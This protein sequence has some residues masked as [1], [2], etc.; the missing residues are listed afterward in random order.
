MLP[1]RS[2]APLL[3]H[4]AFIQFCAAGETTNGGSA[5]GRTFVD[6]YGAANTTTHAPSSQHALLAAAGW[7]QLQASDQRDHDQPQKSAKYHAG[8]GRK[9]QA[10]DAV[11][12]GVTITRS[13]APDQ[14]VT[15]IYDGTGASSSDRFLAVELTYS[16][17]GD[18]YP[19]PLLMVAY[20]AVPVIFYTN[21][22]FTTNATYYDQ[23]A[24]QLVKTYHFVVVDREVPALEPGQWFISVTN[25]PVWSQYS[26]DFSLTVFT[27]PTHPCPR[28]CSLH[29]VCMSD[30]SCAC[31]AGWG[32]TDCSVLM[33]PIAV[34]TQ[35]STHL[36]V[37]EWKYY[38]ITFVGAQDAVDP[39]SFVMA[40]MEITSAP[41]CDALLYFKN[42]DVGFTSLP[43]H[44]DFQHHSDSRSFYSY[45]NKYQVTNQPIRPGQYILG[46]YNYNGRN[47]EAECDITLSVT[48]C[49]DGKCDDTTE[50]VFQST[51]WFLSLF[52]LAGLPLFCFIP[53]FLCI[54]RLRHAQTH[55]RDAGT[56]GITSHLQPAPPRSGLTTEEISALPMFKVGSPEAELFPG[57]ETDTC[58]VC[59][60]AFDDDESVRVL[61]CQH[62]FHAECID[63]WL[64]RQRVCPLCKH[65]QHNVVGTGPEPE[66]ARINRPGTPPRQA[67]DTEGP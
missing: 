18:M 36:D 57:I 17:D 22:Q 29:G 8:R 50:H 64:L 39:D 21:N 4:A 61:V 45:E 27:S 3:L 33:H 10:Y 12:A 58:S 62:C 46:V 35:I 49:Y 41:R 67:V 6:S 32:D 48:A 11:A 15:F 56:R 31:S 20:E 13:L 14:T 25:L 44:Y 60:S 19:D 7:R 43:T 9:L 51:S 66:A 40:D 54:R 23:V 2:A 1:F 16:V 53:F 59:L 24:F 42:A 52:I 55:R 65:D 63:A 5:A 47:I 30:G 34:D 28:S 37:D 26:L 38:Y